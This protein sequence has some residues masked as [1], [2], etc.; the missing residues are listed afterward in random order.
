M[1]V[2]LDAT[3]EIARLCDVLLDDPHELVDA[4]GLERHPDLECLE[5]ARQVEAA[6]G[7]WQSA[8]DHPTRCRCE[9]AGI[10]CERSAVCL[11]IAHEH[12]GALDRER[13]PLVQV[14]AYRVRQLETRNLRAQRIR[15]VRQR[16]ERAIDVEPE[17]LNVA[18][19]RERDEI[20]GRASVHRPRRTDDTEWHQPRGAILGDHPLHRGDVHLVLGVHWHAPKCA[21]PKSEQFGRLARPPVRLSRTVEDEWRA[22]RLAGPRLH[23][24][25]AR[26]EAE[27]ARLGE[28]PDREPERARHRSAGNEHAARAGHP[29]QLGQPSDD[30][31]L[32]QRRRLVESAE[33]RVEPR[34]QH[35][36]HHPEWRP[37]AHHPPR[38][39][40]MQ[41]AVRVWQHVLDELGVGRVGADPGPRNTVR[42]RY[43]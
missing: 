42:R 24:I 16:A 43:A 17:P 36:G 9:V 20:V 10:C 6:I 25:G 1:R 11:G 38:E 37:G 35:V 28:A 26:V 14:E 40:R 21:M 41:V 19:R 12:A 30:L 23:P 13:S 3:D 32:D 5:A 22:H 33:V 34:R 27:L 18:Q 39:A 7:E 8:G 4:V 2:R 15:Q 29:E 31:V